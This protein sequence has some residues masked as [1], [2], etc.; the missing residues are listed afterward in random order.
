MKILVIEDDAATRS[1]LVRGLTEAGYVVD[2]A[3]NGRDGLFLAAG[4]PY[5]LM[6]VD[7]MLPGLDGRASCA[8]CAP[9]G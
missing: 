6:L 4:E 1:Y 3:A 7:R 2:T 5:D 9:R 8:P